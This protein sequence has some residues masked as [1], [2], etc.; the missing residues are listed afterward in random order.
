VDDKTARGPW[1]LNGPLKGDYSI[2]VLGL[3]TPFFRRRLGEMSG[4]PELI[5]KLDRL[6]VLPPVVLPVEIPEIEP[7]RA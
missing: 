5:I 6:P 1:R 4:D 2:D 7:R 3:R